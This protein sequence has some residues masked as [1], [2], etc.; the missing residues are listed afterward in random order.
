MV[1]ICKVFHYKKMSKELHK[2]YYQPD[3]LCS[4]TKLPLKE[5]KTWVKKQ[6][7]WEVHKPP[8]KRIDHPHYYIK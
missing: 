2:I 3:N 5:V 4:E 7:L 6:T 8:P 1:I